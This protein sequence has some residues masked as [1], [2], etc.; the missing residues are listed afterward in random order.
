MAVTFGEDRR[1]R[2]PAPV[3]EEGVLATAKRPGAAS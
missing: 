1:A 3:P 2:A